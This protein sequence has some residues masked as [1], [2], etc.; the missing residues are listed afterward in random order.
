MDRALRSGRARRA[1]A[2]PFASAALEQFRRRQPGRPLVRLAV[3]PRHHEGSMDRNA[4]YYGGSDFGRFVPTYM[5]FVESQ[6]PDRAGSATRP[7]TG[8]TSPSS[9]R[10]RSATPSTTSTSASSTIPATGP[11]RRPIRPGSARSST[12]RR[13]GAARRRLISTFEKWLGRDT[14]YP[15]EPVTCL[16]PDELDDCWAE[17]RLRPDVAAR[18]RQGLAGPD[19]RRPAPYRRYLRDQRRGRGAHL[20]EEQG[21]PSH[22]L[23]RAKRADG[24]DLS[25]HAARRPHLQAQSGQARQAA[26]GR[27]VAADRAFWDAYAAR[28]LADPDFRIDD[29][30][31]ITFG[32]LAFNHADLYRWRK[33]PKDEEYFLKLALRLSPQLQD[34]VLRAAGPLCRPGPVRRGGRAPAPGAARRSAQRGPTARC[35]PTTSGGA[36]HPRKRK[37][38]ARS[39]RFP[40]TISPPISSS[41]ACCNSRAAKRSRSSSACAAPPR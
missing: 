7:S 20:P 12:I 4:V 33:M 13:N 11:R 6:Q 14:A 25:L 30:A 17:Y 36:T 15:L 3:R 28:L 27:A 40:R 5:E 24:L 23:P 16:S 32:K 39:S 31:T 37:R 22:L 34:A 26:A 8:A 38:C 1:D 18:I 19:G 41:R 2:L 9:R 29:D 21:G 10:T 35:W